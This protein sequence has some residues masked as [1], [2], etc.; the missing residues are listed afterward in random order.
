MADNMTGETTFELDAGLEQ[1][2]AVLEA[3]EIEDTAIT[4]TEL[5][6]GAN[7]L[8]AGEQPAVVEQ[9]AQ[10][11]GAATT[12]AQATDGRTYTQADIDQIIG[13]RLHGE[14]ARLQRDFAQQHAEDIALAAQMRAL[15]SG[16]TQ[17]QISARLL[18][19]RAQ[20]MAQAENVPVAMAKRILTLEAKVGMQAQPVAQAPDSPPPAQGTP[21]S[22]ARMQA[23]AEQAQWLQQNAGVDAVAL[24]QANPDIADRI[25]RGEM[26]LYQAAAQRGSARTTPAA[27]PVVRGGGRSVAL[28]VSKMSDADFAKITDELA[29]GNAVQLG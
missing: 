28:D 8:D 25:S 29:R 13:Q 27:P 12:P 23:L 16:E 24:L 22:N 3:P 20:E 18:D 4:L 21:A 10:T 2:A 11:N 19:A 6:G 17:E 5:L 1:D 26:D 7:T 9:E 14:R 15:Y